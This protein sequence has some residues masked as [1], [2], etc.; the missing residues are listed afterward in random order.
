MEATEVK[1]VERSE[2]KAHFIDLSQQEVGDV[3]HENRER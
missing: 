3:G 2:D 1:E